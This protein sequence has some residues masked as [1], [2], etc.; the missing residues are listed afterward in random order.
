MINFIFN[1]LLVGFFIIL[2]SISSLYIMI[3]MVPG[4]PIKVLLGPRATIEMQ[5]AISIKLLLKSSG[6]FLISIFFY[7]ISWK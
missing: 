2:A 7:I 5:E 3:H 4:D 6:T 1:K